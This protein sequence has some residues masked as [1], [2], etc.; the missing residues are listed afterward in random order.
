MKTL[1]ILIVDDEPLARRRLKRLLKRAGF[2]EVEE[3]RSGEQ[4]VAAIQSDPPDLV[5]LDI[6]MPGMNGFQVVRAVGV[7]R[8]PT[9]I[10]VTAYDEYALQAFEV[11]AMDY[12]LKP[13]EEERLTS[14][15]QRVRARMAD[16]TTEK[17]RQALTALVARLWPDAD[18]A[19]E[20]PAQGRRYLERLLV[21]FGQQTRFLRAA[22]VDWIEAEGNYARLHV[23]GKNCLIRETLVSLERMLNPAQ[24]LRVHR[25]AIV[26]LERIAHLEPSFGGNYIV[27]L[28]TGTELTLSR[29]YRQRMQAVIATYT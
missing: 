24:F 8:M 22:E 14:A 27:R 11:H 2:E 18:A 23:A 21:N 17:D 26:N 5:L 1:R 15:I 10:F 28:T 20:Q 25:S 3:C 29:R 12:L 4:A 9:T 13:L 7:D 6:Q 19:P 16:Q